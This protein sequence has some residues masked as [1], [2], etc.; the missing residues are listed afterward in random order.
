MNRILPVIGPPFVAVVET[1]HSLRFD[2][3]TC[4]MLVF[5]LAGVLSYAAHRTVRIIAAR[6]SGLDVPVFGVAPLLARRVGGEWRVKLGASPGTAPFMG[7]FS[8][9]SIAPSSL[10]SDAFVRAV[11]RT[12]LAG[13]ML[14]LGVVLVAGLAYWRAGDPQ[15]MSI[16]M[17]LSMVTFSL[18]S[19]NVALSATLIPMRVSRFRSDGAMIRLL[20]I[21]RDAAT[22]QSMFRTSALALDA[23]RPREWSFDE[24]ETLRQT[25]LVPPSTPLQ[26]EH[27]AEAAFLLTLTY[28]DH[29]R[30][31]DAS[32]VTAYMLGFIEP[33]GPAPP[34]MHLQVVLAAYLTVVLHSN[35]LYAQAMLDRIPRRT[36]V[37]ASAP[38]RAAEAAL[39]V[40]YGH[41]DHARRSAL[42][43]RKTAA[44]AARL[45]PIAAVEV[46][47]AN[48]VL[49]VLDRSPFYSVATA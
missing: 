46:D 42:S 5:S 19:A 9:M 30:H 45:F 17:V 41:R 48:A 24:V 10:L 32:R 18:L 28:L 1:W 25:V 34:F 16:G 33:L 26:R 47:L 2:V 12:I 40:A 14:S 36:A 20:S 21:P 31:E 13:P 35:T 4:A 37:H 22:V 11:R 7:A 29:H 44:C 3:L 8:F 38:Y 23:R 43:A 15:P 6:R 39:A 49:T 27:Q